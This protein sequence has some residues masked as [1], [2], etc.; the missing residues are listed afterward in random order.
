MF[1]AG[2]LFEANRT[3]PARTKINRGGT[4]SGK[5]YSIMQLLFHRAITQP[6]TKITI[7]G[8]S[9]PNLKRGAYLD[10]ENIY[11]DSD[12]LKHFVKTWHRTD[13]KIYFTGGSMMEFATY[14]NELSARAG[15]R[16]ILFLNE[17]NSI[18]YNVFWQLDMRTIDKVT[19]NGT[20]KSEVFIDYNPSSKFWVE[21]K[22]IGTEGVGL[23]ISDHR[24]NPW[25]TEDA[26][27]K[28][29]AIP[30]PELW[31]V[32]ARGMVG[33]ITGIIYPNWK[34][35]SD[36]EFDRLTEDMPYG[37][38][39]DYGDTDPTA[40]VKVYYAGRQRFIKEIEYTAGLTPD[41]IKQVLIAHGYNDHTLVFCDHNKP[42]TTALLRRIEV[43]RAMPAIKGPGSINAGIAF[44]KE[45]NVFYNESS[46]N[47]HDEVGKYVWLKDTKTGES[48]ET[49][50]D[51]FNHLLDASRYFVYSHGAPLVGKKR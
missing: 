7:V 34:R 40:I 10:A 50:I 4:S 24:H 43:K 41:Q 29:E 2:P 46:V 39:V 14:E 28:I 20:I 25:L 6:G 49:P 38:G 17:A 31:K 44:F 51:S 21:E 19:P 45:F 5:T 22:L 48:T 37:F 9:V 15:K 33:N 36:K 42:Q 32:Y 12:I 11:A 27:K 30:D 26:H 18:S 47:L 35:L 13:R 8:E 3:H 23:I 1:A 16:Q